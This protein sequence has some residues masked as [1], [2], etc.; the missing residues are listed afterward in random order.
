MGGVDI[1]HVD[2]DKGLASLTADLL[3]R[4][5]SRFN[6]QTAASAT[7]GLHL[8]DEFAPD[9]IISDFEMPGRDGLEFLEAVRAEHSKLP[10]ILFTGRGSEEIASDAISAGATDYLQ[11]Q[12]GTEQ[13]EL[14][15]NRINNAVTRYHSEK[16]LRETKEEYA[17]VFE[18]ARNGLLLVDVEQD[19]FRFRRCNSRVLEFTGLAESELIGKTPQEALGHENARTVAGAYRK[20]VA[21]R[22]TISYTVTL[23]HPVGDVIHEVNTTPIIRDGE[24]EQLVVAFTD[25]TERYA[26]E[27]ELREERA[28]IQQALDTL[29]DPL[30][31]IDI[32]GHL[33]HC[34]RRALELIGHTEDTAVGTPITDLFPDDERV[35]I[36]DAVDDALRT[37]RTTVT[38]SLRLDSG[39]RQ[40]YEFRAHSLTDLDNNTAGLV[41]VGQDAPD[42]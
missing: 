17:A 19:G 42:S 15:A 30:F 4:K 37:G 7:E 13:Y 31:V 26:R 32:D 27:Q 5:D 35:T 2:D 34:N 23:T 39:Q 25:I 41:I 14:L 8:L 21:M 1:L 9:C 38:A 28:V 18:N 33:K 16:Q 29:D 12:S 3:E 20:C 10:F 11:K 36:T 40:S 22:E 24:V 6:V